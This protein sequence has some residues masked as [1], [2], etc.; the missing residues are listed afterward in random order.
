[1]TTL[2]TYL[3]NIGLSTTLQYFLIQ[4]VLSRFFGKQ[5]YVEGKQ[6]LEGLCASEIAHA[7]QFSI[8]DYQ[9]A[10]PVFFGVN[11]RQDVSVR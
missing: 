5:E 6:L 7:A 1:M 4:H 2:C 9:L 10:L 8:R 3:K 11:N